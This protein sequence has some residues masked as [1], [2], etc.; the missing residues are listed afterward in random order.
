MTIHTVTMYLY[1]DRF[2]LVIILV[3]TIL[4]TMPKKND[5]MGNP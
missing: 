1:F 3:D 4:G 5:K 2:R